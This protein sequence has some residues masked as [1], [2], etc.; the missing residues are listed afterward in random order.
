MIVPTIIV[1]IYL[2]IKTY[3]E[4]NDEYLI[5][6][7]ICFWVIA[8]SYWMICEFINREDIKNYAGI[9]FVAGMLCV[10]LYY[11]KNFSFKK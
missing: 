6:L 1:A 7:A 8:N 10:S 5:N 2:T 3:K 9:S 4:K 11:Y